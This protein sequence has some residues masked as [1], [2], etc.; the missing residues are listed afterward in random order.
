[1]FDIDVM[2]DDEIYRVFLALSYSGLGYAFMCYNWY[3]RQYEG[4]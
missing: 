2:T 4:I 1:M 3:N